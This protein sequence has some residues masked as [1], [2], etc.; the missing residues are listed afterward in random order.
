MKKSTITILA[1][2]MGFSFACL[3][4]LQVRYIDEILGMRK[5][6]FEEYVSRSIN[7]V[8]H[9]LEVDEATRYLEQGSDAMIGIATAID[10]VMVSTDSAVIQRT[11]QVR[12]KDGSVFTSLETTASTSM[13][14]KYFTKR[15]AGAH[16][17]KIR[18]LQ[19]IMA[20]RY[21]YEKSLLDEVIYSILYTAHDRPLA[22]RMDFKQL[23]QYLKSELYN[24]DIR[25]KYHFAVETNNGEV[26]YKCPDYEE[27]GSDKAFTVA[28]FQNDPV[29]KAGVLKVHFPKQSEFIYHSIWFITP[30]LIF[31]LVLLVTFIVTLVLIFRQKKLTEVK[32]DFINN[33]THEFKTPISSISLAAQ[34]LGDD[35]VKKTP[36]L[37]QRLTSTIMDETKRLR[38]QV[39][40]VLQLSMYE[41]QNANLRKQDV[42][43]NE[44][45]A[46]V[47]HTFALKVEKN[48]G[49]II[50]QTDATDPFVYVDDMHFT[51][52]V[53][54]L[55]D[56]AVKYKRNDTELELKVMTWNESG[57]VC[58]SIQDNGIG[59]AKDDL[60]RIFEK[61]YRV[62]TGNLHDVKGFGLGL[63][64]VKKIV[65]DHKG[66]IHAESELGIGTK[67]IIKLPV[68]KPEA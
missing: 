19:E 60:K 57:K 36:Q 37:M 9:K 44:L 50:T 18:S 15:N 35:S 53:F 68:V 54:N 49:K 56:N 38:F 28:L 46:G 7:Q 47:V 3:L 34:M 32:N 29:Q 42:D 17:D 51:N 2:V 30:S 6:H 12:A 64:Y 11:H 25:L 59:I 27:E 55:M 4:G 14:D 13:S 31:T 66:T 63:A 58:L 41:H 16:A 33:M 10:S 48:G 26:I 8:A 45:V 20:R 1:V 23:D 22:E 61:F 67:F 43:I 5:A 24:N 62:H 52:V 39:E 65:E 21:S 40:K